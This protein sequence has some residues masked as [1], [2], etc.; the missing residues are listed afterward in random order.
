[1]ELAITVTEVLRNFAEYVNRVVYRGESFL[2]LRGGKPVALLSP[3]PSGR[4]LGDL[5][6]LLATLPRLAPEEAEAFGKDLEQARVHPD[7]EAE[8]DHWES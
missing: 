6:A 1:M 3:V 7:A 8:R 4:R 5:P 2:L